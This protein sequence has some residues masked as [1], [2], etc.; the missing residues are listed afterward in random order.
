[1]YR[2]MIS[3]KEKTQRK[4]KLNSRKVPGRVRGFRPDVPASGRDRSRL[5]RKAHGE[6]CCGL[7]FPEVQDHPG[8]KGTPGGDQN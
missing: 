3:R 1:M 8:R 5:K 6:R 4:R 2:Q 7:R